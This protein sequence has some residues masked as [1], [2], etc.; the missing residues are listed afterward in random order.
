MMGLTLL[1]TCEW[2]PHVL[3]YSRRICVVDLQ[4]LIHQIS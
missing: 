2:T 3:E 4:M 1:I